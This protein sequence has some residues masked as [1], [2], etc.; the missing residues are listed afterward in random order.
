[1]KKILEDKNKVLIL[2]NGNFYIPQF[3]KLDGDKHCIENTL[4]L[5]HRKYTEKIVRDPY[6]LLTQGIIM[7]YVFF[8]S[9]NFWGINPFCIILD[10]YI[11]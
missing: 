7:E 10:V 4:K 1:M 3:M 11:V 5:V 8:Q 6:L 2:G 9:K